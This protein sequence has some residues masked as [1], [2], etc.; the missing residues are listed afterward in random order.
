MAKQNPIFN[1]RFS[2]LQETIEDKCIDLVQEYGD[3]IIE[4]ILKEEFDPEQICAI[5]T[6]CNVS[7]TSTWGEIWL[8]V[9]SRVRT[10]CGAWV[11]LSSLCLTVVTVIAESPKVMISLRSWAPFVLIKKYFRSLDRRVSFV[12]TVIWN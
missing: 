12:D 6:L 8:F 2:K 4:I 1:F 9:C 7:A 11:P 5:L 3:Q 10:R